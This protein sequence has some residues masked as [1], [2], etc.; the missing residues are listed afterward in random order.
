MLNSKFL[1]NIL[2]KLLTT[3][4]FTI[5]CLTPNKYDLVI[6]LLSKNPSMTGKIT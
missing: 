3:T 2:I 5:K 1:Q 4:T 6:E